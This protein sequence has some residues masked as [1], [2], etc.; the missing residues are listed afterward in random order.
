MESSGGCK[1]KPVEWGIRTHRGAERGHPPV[2]GT[3]GQVIEGNGFPVQLHILPDSK[4]AFHRRDQKLPWV[5][6][7]RGQS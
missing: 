4:H 1:V 2:T 3:D 6:P 5:P 7:R